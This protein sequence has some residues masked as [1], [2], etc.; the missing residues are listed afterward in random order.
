MRSTV[1]KESQ[2]DLRRLNKALRTIIG[3]S[4]ALVRASDESTLL[5]DVCRVIVDAGEYPL[6]WVGYALDDEQRS[7]KPMAQA[8]YEE[9]HLEQL[10]ITWS[11]TETGN[12]PAGTA[13]RTGKPSV[14][15]DM[16]MHPAYGP[17]RTDAIKHG[18][19]SSIALPLIA[20][21]RPIGSL[22]IYA[23]ERHAFKREEVDLLMQLARNLSYGIV[24][25]RARAEQQETEE[26]IRRNEELFRLITDNVE[27]LIAIIDLEGRRVYNS[28]SYA[29]ILGDPERLKGTDSVA[30]IHADDREK[31]RQILQETVTTGMGRRSEYR[32]VAA[33]GS[34]RFI[35]SQGTV[36]RDASGSVSSVLVVSRDVTARKAAEEER[37]ILQEQ[38]RQ[39]QKLESIGTLAGGIAHDFNNILTIILGYLPLL[40]QSNLNPGER[41]KLIDTMNKTVDRG[42]ELVRQLLTFASKSDV[43]FGRVNINAIIADLERVITETFP[44]NITFLIESDDDIPSLFADAGQIHQAL[45][46]LCVN[47][48]DAMPNGG[49]LGISTG[50]VPAAA[51]VK[52]F[53]GLLE[54]NYVRISVTD[55][56]MGMDEA[57][58]ERMFEPFFTT[59]EEGKGTGLG[60]AV[61]YG[62][63]QTHHAYVDVESTPGLGT[64]FNLYFP[65]QAQT[66][67]AAEEH[68][69]KYEESPGGNE[70]I[71]VIEDEQ[72]QLDLVTLLLEGKGYKIL[73]AGDGAEGVEV[74]RKYKETI[75]LVVSDMGLPRKTGLEAFLKIKEIN[76]QANVMFA[77]GYLDTDLKNE[78]LKEGARDFLQKPYEPNEILRKIRDVIDGQ[79]RI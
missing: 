48:R 68:T 25:L 36:I 42:A 28:P 4:E 38:L 3:C 47:A 57:T 72:V 33:D 31:I 23:R 64:T 55:T 32:F 50:R 75:S 54:E 41:S 35:E 11:D 52:R 9:G 40:S 1:K 67:D 2:E 26:K 8:G 65:A 70:T 61:V 20:G 71:L 12:A 60:L 76:P 14:V 46:N 49:E 73:S 37:T 17:W 63:A 5:N 43:S 69:K 21:D 39:A 59:K 22:N 44:R 6:A 7:V 53:T 15:D 13:I 56:G 51:L 29:R 62:V 16:R 79:R 27:D 24:T 10:N 77:S 19:G 78:I 58:K 30:E 34:I 66:P 45:L 18:L 74:Y